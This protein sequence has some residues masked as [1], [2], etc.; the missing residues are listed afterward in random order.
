MKKSLDD[1]V[2]CKRRQAPVGQQKMA[3]LPEDRVT[4]DKPPFTF[5]GVDCFGPF[6][7]RR[8]RSMVKRYGVLFT[9]LTLRAIHIE[10][11]HSLDTDSY[12]N[13]MR[14]F[15]VRRGDPEEMRSDNGSN[16]VSAERELREEIAKWN[17][18]KIYQFLVQR[19]VEWVFNPP[20]GSH[21]GGVWE[22]YIRT[23]R[24][25][26]RSLMK[27]QTLDDE[28][29]ATLMCE[30]E[31][32][33][34]RRPIS[35]VSDDPKDMEAL[36]P[37]HLLLLRSGPTLPPGVFRKEDTYSRRRWRQAQY[38]ADVFW[39]R[40]VREYLPALQQRQKWINRQRNF[41]E[42]DIVLV[43]DDSAP[44]NSWPLGRIL[45][46]QGNSRDGCVRRVKVKTRASVLV[47][48]IDKIVLLEAAQ[49]RD[50]DTK[51]H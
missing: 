45:E 46:T 37:N 38:L 26:M 33:V 49:S 51:T 13:T 18:Q 20:A 34:N 16:F 5:V 1:C 35:K 29:L 23:V 8:G 14:R 3:D 25:L 41:A 44:R 24:K 27:E 31:S 10:V 2:N 19:N 32:I 12:V 48:P 9:C 39:R 47:R 21:H 15:I 11:I 36:T 6:L 4:P 50:A 42:G 7:V 17:Q 30:V 22:R 28:G 43:V 40:W